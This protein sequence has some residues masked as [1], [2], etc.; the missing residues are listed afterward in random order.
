MTFSKILP[1]Y[2]RRYINANQSVRMNVGFQRAQSLG[3]LYSYDNL[4]KHQAVLRLAEKLQAMGK[5]LVGLCYVTVQHHQSF[6]PSLTHRDVQLF[7]KITNQQAQ[8][9]IDTPFDYLYH[10]DLFSNPVLDYLLAKS[11]ARCRV[12]HFDAARAGL[13]EMMVKFDRKPGSNHIDDLI[14]QMLHYTQHLKAK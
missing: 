8:D 11:K 14:E 9:F 13:F 2:T 10:V 7:G 6:F 12:G 5:Q 1:W 4:E 3:L